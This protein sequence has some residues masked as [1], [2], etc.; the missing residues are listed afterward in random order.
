MI[1]CR[2]ILGS[3]LFASA[4]WGGIVVTTSGER[5]EG[6]LKKTPSGWRVTQTD[7]S[8]REV[9]AAEVRAIELNS[10]GAGNQMERLDSLRRS[11]EAF[12]D[13][14]KIIDRYRRFIEQ[15]KDKPVIDAA[16]ADVKTWQERLDKGLVKVGKRWMT[17]EEKRDLA[18]DI[19][20]RVEEARQQIKAQDIASAQRTI[21]S[22]LDDEPD[23]ISAVYLTAVILQQQGKSIEAETR[24]RDVLKS[25]VDHAPTLNNLAVL[26][27]RQKQWPAACAMMEQALAAEPNVQMLIDSAAELLEMLPADQRKSTSAQKLRQRFATQDGAMQKTM[28][29]R[30]MY[31][32]GAKWVDQPTRDQLA[33]AEKGVKTRLDEL[34]GDFDLTQGRIDRIDVEVT[35]NERTLREIESRS[36][37]RTADGS[38]IRVPYP[39]AYYDIQRDIN[40]LRAERGEMNKRLESLR[41]AAK[42]AQAELPVPKYAGSIPAI[43]EDGVPIVVPAGLGLADIQSPP[44]AGSQPATQQAAPPPPIIRIGPAGD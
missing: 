11:V 13:I 30:Q 7:G 40:R 29:A 16:I 3:L 10:T 37:I 44:A 1:S 41:D 39:P 23:N 6:D 15:V 17:P 28:A 14:P 22:I 9:A 33:E 20:R 43:G 24:F 34:Q 42:R 18:V 5:I 35:Q 26:N 4:A 36:F 8:V 21:A 32:W 2:S 31:R 25:I 38:Y 12:E 27:A 19:I